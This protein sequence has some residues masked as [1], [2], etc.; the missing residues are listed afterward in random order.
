MPSAAADK[1]AEERRSP[2][3][4]VV[5]EAVLKEGDEELERP[6]SALFWSG[7]AA[8]L[9]M[10]LSMFAEALLRTALPDAEWTPLITKLGYS[11]GFVVVILGRQ[12]LFTENTLTP[13]LPLFQNKDAKTLGNVMRLWA[14]VLT[15]NL[16][17]ALAI[18]YV[19]ARTGVFDA[20]MQQAFAEIGE[21]ALATD[22]G[23][24]MLRAIFAGW[25]IA[26]I[27]W[28]LPFA[29]SA[30]LAVIVILTYLIGLGHFSH[31]IAGAVVVFTG[32]WSGQVPWADG[33]L[34]YIAPALVGNII[35]GVALVAALNHAQVVAGSE[36]DD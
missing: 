11:V 13:M 2:S 27:V 35:G 36:S 19:S 32:S 29:E 8:G 10:A 24:V 22:A 16:I 26:L 12:Q 15:A 31:V 3:G 5:Y 33:V 21:E 25:L 30:R 18:A 34:G 1:E 9:S 17:G 23:T 4:R 6:S 14:I 20:S 28:L 7:L